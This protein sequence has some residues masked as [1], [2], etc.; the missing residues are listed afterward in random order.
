MTL[1][2]TASGIA[3]EDMTGSGYLNELGRSYGC[4]CG[5]GCAAT[6]IGTVDLSPNAEASDA[7]SP[8]NR[9]Q[10]EQLKRCTRRYEEDPHPVLYSLTLFGLLRIAMLPG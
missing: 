10:K 7:V 9:L 4:G 2:A 8:T 5:C 6:V 3:K 1:G